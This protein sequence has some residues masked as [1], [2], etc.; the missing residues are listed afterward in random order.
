MR[1]ALLVLAGLFLI[2]SYGFAA[3]YQTVIVTPVEVSGPQRP[4]TGLRADHISALQ[5]VARLSQAR[6]L[7]HLASLSG[8]SD[9]PA[10]VKQVHPLWLVNRIVVTATPKVVAQL[11]ARD[12]VK[13]VRPARTVKLIA[14]VAEPGAGAPAERDQ[15]YGLGKIRAP[16]VWKQL[17][18]TGNG[19][20]VG[21]LDSG[22]YGLHPDIKDKIVKFRDFFVS[23]QQTAFD[24]L[25][26]GT[27]TA[28]TIVGGATSGKAIGVAPGAKLIVGRIFDGQGTTTDAV[29]LR[30]M[31]WIADPDGNP[32]TNDAPR[33]VSNSWGG[34]Q[35]SE[36]PGD[37]LWQAAQHWVD[38]GMLP[39]FSGGNS[40]PT[41][42]VGVPGGYPHVVA[43]GSTNWF[44][45]ASMFSSRGPVK[46]EGVE[47]VKP[48]VCAPGSSVTSAKDLG[49]Y[50]SMS[51]TSMSCPHVAGVV[52]LMLEANADLTVP[53]MV[54]IL[55]STAKDLGSTGR[56]N[57]YGWGL[58][59]ALAAVQKAKALARFQAGRD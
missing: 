36:T 13:Q 11:G 22:A 50:T 57:T 32:S 37:D 40:G 49:G 48:D 16:E 19:V 21:H 31:N 42:K 39:L 1:S 7:R 51:G 23:D 35:D 5:E 4:D 34:T 41:G 15:T 29:I 3:P 58:V 52:A 25:G 28:G 45:W 6:I 56:D 2:S 46:W 17:A 12:D 47:Y 54:E 10:P 27:H 30:A 59:D 14:P 20:L 24:G 38:L 33:L 26:H 18:I 9:E 43:V 8:L 55:R 44:N 53:Q